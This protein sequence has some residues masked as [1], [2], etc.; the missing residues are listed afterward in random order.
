[1]TVGFNAALRK[2]V[3]I[4]F[5]TCAIQFSTKFNLRSLFGV[6]VCQL[7]KVSNVSVFPTGG[8]LILLHITTN[9]RLNYVY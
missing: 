9:D 6:I 1:M 4:G 5:L 3:E 7:N 8:D 2:Y